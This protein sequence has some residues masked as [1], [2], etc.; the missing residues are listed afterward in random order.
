V[1]LTGAGTAVCK[2]AK[3]LITSSVT[4]TVKYPGSS[5]YLSSTGSLSQIVS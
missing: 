2:I 4:V 3:G 1:K 5:D